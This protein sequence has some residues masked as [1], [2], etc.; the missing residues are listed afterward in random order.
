M[1]YL[2]LMTCAAVGLMAADATGTWT[3]TLH[4]EGRD[5]G[6]AHLVLKQDGVKLTGTAGPG[7]GEQ[8]EI[9]NGKAEDGKITFEVAGD[10]PPMKFVLKQDG[11]EIKGEVSREREGEMQK[12]QLA[13]TRSK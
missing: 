4:P 9:Q 11:E 12:A 3:G 6:P 1:K 5:A 10:G 13:V 2:L 8:H 7:P